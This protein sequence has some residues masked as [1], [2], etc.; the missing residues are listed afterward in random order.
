MEA[1][2]NGDTTSA[3]AVL[4]KLPAYGETV[5]LA[6]V[7]ETCRGNH[8]ACLTL[9]LPYV[10]TTQ[11]G[12]GIL[13]SECVHA[14]HVACTEVLL[15]HWKSVCSNVTFVPH[16]SKHRADEAKVS[17]PAMWSD[18]A[19]C[20]VLID[21][22]ADVH[23]KNENGLSPLHY[24]C[25]SVGGDADV[26]Q[27]LL[28]AGAD[29]EMKNSDGYSPLHSACASGAL[30]IVKMLVEAGA[31]VR[32][33]EKTGE[34]CLMLAA[35]FG[36]TETVR[37]LVGLP[38]V[39][40][41]HG[42]DENDTALHHAVEQNHADIVQV[43]IDAGADT[44]TQNTDG[45]SPVDLA[46][47]SGA[48]Q[49]VQML[50]R[51]GAEVCFTDN[52]GR[53]CLMLA[54]G[55]G[56]TETVRY[57]VGLPD[58]EL[59]REEGKTALHCAV[60]E[61]CA[62]IVQV[63]IAAGADMDTKDYTGLSALHYA[64]NH[65]L[66]DIVKMLVEAGAGVRA[67]DNNGDTF[68]ILAAYHGSTDTVRYFLCL[69]EIE[70]NHRADDNKTAL[71]CAVEENHT[72]I[73]Q[74]LIDAGADMDTK[75][76]EGRSP[77]HY[78]CIDG[79]LDI[80]KMLVEAGAGVR[81][82]DND[83]DTCLTLAAYHGHIE[84]VRYLVGLPGVD[85]NHRG[86]DNK[87]ALLCAVEEN[88]T[89][90][91]QLLIA[92]G[93]DIEMKNSDGRSPLH[94]ACKSGA[95]DIVK[96]LVEAGAGVRAT[97]N[98]GHTCLILAACFG[99][100]ETVRYLVGLPQMDV[101]QREGNHQT[102]LQWA[103]E[104]NDTHIAQ[105]LIDAGADINTEYSDGP[106]PVHTASFSG[107]L[108]VVKMLVR[109]GAGVCVTDNTC[110]GDT[111][112]TCLMI[113]AH[114]GHTD[115]VRY[116]VGLPEV[117][118]N[119][120]ADDNKTALHWAVESNHTEIAQLLIDA[121]ADMDIKDSM[122]NSP[123]HDACCFG[124]L[125]IVKMLVEVGAGVRATDDQGDTCLMLAAHFGNTETVR[126]LLSLPE[127]EVN[128]RADDDKTALQCAVDQN[129]T[130]IAQLLIAAGADMDTENTDGRSP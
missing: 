55:R 24:A 99:H 3:R 103:V 70:L 120:L 42:G 69:P 90:I 15:Q 46:S 123:L 21:A 87:T 38:E 36:H 6:S 4:E 122:G 48:L 72:D 88:H 22:G 40:V 115:T 81:A 34:T 117:E 45:R 23:T 57:L 65:G 39:E 93:A 110:L 12:F 16:A 68:L 89:D 106:F 92:A 17:C 75:D 63:L 44:D 121:G 129:H 9:L 7:H 85:V 60:E 78:A 109:V 20:R 74:L 114:C 35:Y 67:A 50:V 1:A 128:H 104:A 124:T 25:S 73:A 77:L 11:V 49:I 18:P 105:L 59:N 130:D 51:V 116:L 82:T 14:N 54:A 108:D 56:H 30:E 52:T 94:H 107:A 98:Q 2:K 62:D 119:Q 47:F 100:T 91:A 31:G 10:E 86:A 8:Y 66:I 26:V 126:Y 29:I 53:T 102:A 19:V 64:C 111:G 80:V 27:V 101:N 96:M 41:N 95:H 76:N 71:L 43:L 83:E 118:V 13:L 125:D 33:T 37:Y 79:A 112:C 127:V 113:A 61:N 58:V 84:T 28:D 32:V 97:D 5:V